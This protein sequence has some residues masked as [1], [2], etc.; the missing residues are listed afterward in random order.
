VTSPTPTDAVQ[1]MM[2]NKKYSDVTVNFFGSFLSL[3]LDSLF[4]VLVPPL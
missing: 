2:Q 4:F 1:A 3:F